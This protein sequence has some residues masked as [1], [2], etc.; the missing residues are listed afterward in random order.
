MSTPYSQRECSGR[1]SSILRLRVAHSPSQWFLPDPERMRGG[2]QRCGSL[3]RGS[4]NVETRQNPPCDPGPEILC[5]I[6]RLR[7]HGLDGVDSL[8]EAREVTF[9]ETKWPEASMGSQFTI[10][11]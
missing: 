8:R 11:L 9:G 4:F 3:A 7:N 6:S 10:N 1:N 2:A 5:Q